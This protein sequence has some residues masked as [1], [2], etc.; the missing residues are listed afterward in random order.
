MICVYF[1]LPNNRNCTILQCGYYF[2]SFQ[3]QKSISD[4][5]MLISWSLIK[6]RFTFYIAKFGKF[7]IYVHIDKPK[8]FSNYDYLKN[9]DDVQKINP[10]NEYKQLNISSRNGSNS[11]K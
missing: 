10:F 7:Y 3:F 11:S 8:N 2:E 6:S 5:A 4:N 1:Y 9:K